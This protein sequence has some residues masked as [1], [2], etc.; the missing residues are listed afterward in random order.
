MRSDIAIRL[1]AA[2]AARDLSALRSAAGHAC[3]LHFLHR[4]VSQPLLTTERITRH[5]AVSWLPAPLPGAA[6]GFEM[7][8]TLIVAA[9]GQPRVRSFSD[10]LGFVSGPA[11][12]SLNAMR[13]GHPMSSETENRLLLLLHSRAKAHKL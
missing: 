10:T 6:G 3:I 13:V 11:E 4:V 2:D 8:V 12:V 7:R 1:S 5:V 9:A